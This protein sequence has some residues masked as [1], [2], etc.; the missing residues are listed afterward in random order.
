MGALKSIIEFINGANVASAAL[1]VD[2]ICGKATVKRMQAFFGTTQDGVISGQDESLKDCYPNLKSVEFGKG[3][4]PCIKNMQRW[5]GIAQDGILGNNTIKALQ[6]KLGVTQ[7]GIMGVKTVKAWQKYLN[8]HN[9]ATYPTTS[10]GA[11]IGAKAN[12]LAWSTNTSKAKYPNGAPTAAFKAALKKAYP[13]RSSWGKAPRLGASCDVFVGTCVRAAGVDKNFPRG[14]SFTY[15][16]K[17]SKF[18]QVK[19]TKSTIQ[20][21][22]IILYKKKNGGG[23]ICI[24]YNGK[25]KEAGLKN[26]YGKTTDKVSS[27]LSTS[28]KAWVKVFRAK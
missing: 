17:S 20:N 12:E 11:K 10:N 13:N 9:K 1:V 2:G 26:F 28:G 8:S 19:V 5:L 18:K 22:D 27:R 16:P 15:L 23:H 6:R 4:S 24:Y 25:I 3:G 7:D 21:G 14:L